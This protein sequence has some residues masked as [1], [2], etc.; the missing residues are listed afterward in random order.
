MHRQG[1]SRVKGSTVGGNDRNT[2]NLYSTTHTLSSLRQAHPSWRVGLS[3]IV[4]LQCLGSRVMFHDRNG[5]GYI[6]V[7]TIVISREQTHAHTHTP[8]LPNYM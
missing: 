7:S 2:C 1:H 6:H 4:R 8:Q 3:M 5:T